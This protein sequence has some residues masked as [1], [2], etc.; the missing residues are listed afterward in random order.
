MVMYG[1][2]GIS[3]RRAVGFTRLEEAAEKSGAASEYTISVELVIRSTAVSF[4][5]ATYS[6]ID[7][8]PSKNI[9]IRVTDA[10]LASEC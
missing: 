6:H 3:E 10:V 4:I 8:L 5:V 2:M 7:I 1:C 9:I